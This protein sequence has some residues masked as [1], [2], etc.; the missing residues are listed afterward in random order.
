V[1]PDP[2]P[3]PLPNLRRFEFLTFMIWVGLA[4]AV[5]VLLIDYQIKNSILESAAKARRL[6]DAVEGQARGTNFAANSHGSVG[7][8]V[9]GNDGSWV[10]VATVAI[11][12]TGGV[13]SGLPSGNSHANGRSGIGNPRVQGSDT[14]G[15]NK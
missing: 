14:T 6:I 13:E 7:R 11:P 12:D 8:G 9:R 15:D 3:A 2:I 10:E 1:M 4:G 5:L